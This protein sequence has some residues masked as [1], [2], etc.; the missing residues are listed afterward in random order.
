MTRHPKAF[1]DATL[2]AAMT[3]IAVVMPD[4]GS[5][6]SCAETDGLGTGR[7]GLASPGPAVQAALPGAAGQRASSTT[8]TGRGLILALPASPPPRRT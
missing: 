7:P 8:P 4:P 2:L 6:Q 1:T 5:W 3:G